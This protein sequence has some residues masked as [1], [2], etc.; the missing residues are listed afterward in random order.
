MERLSRFAES[1]E[2]LY[3]HTTFLIKIPHSLLDIRHFFLPHRFNAIRSF[4]FEFTWTQLLKLPNKWYRSGLDRDKWNKVWDVIR[5]MPCLESLRI[6]VAEGW[7]R[8]PG[9]CVIRRHQP[10]T[11]T[12][13]LMLEPLL[14]VTRPSDFVVT[15]HWRPSNPSS[16]DNAPF[17]LKFPRA[18]LR[19]PYPMRTAEEHEFIPP[20]QQSTTE[21]V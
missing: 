5:C 6:D 18:G 3:T 8:I 16:Y 20:E 12:E 1:I 7:G 14:T 13:A 10:P 2:Y 17:K 19:S 21:P 15:L 9:Q 4:R 11:Q